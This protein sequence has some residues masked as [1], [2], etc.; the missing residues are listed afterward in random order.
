MSISIKNS[1]T[2]TKWEVALQKGDLPSAGEINDCDDNSWLIS[3]LRQLADKIESE[4]PRIINIGL[5]TD[6]Q[7]KCPNLYLELFERNK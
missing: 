7:Y 5:S 6:S 4:N 1:T 3:S 2:S